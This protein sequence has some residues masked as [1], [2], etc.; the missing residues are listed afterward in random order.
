MTADLIM[1][2]WCHIAQLPLLAL[3]EMFG[4]VAATENKTQ[5]MLLVRTVRCGES[6]SGQLSQAHWV[7][8]IYWSY[9]VVL[10]KDPVM[11][12]SNAFVL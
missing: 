1:F 8:K 5:A 4:F 7:K 6:D 10:F 11:W 3:V 2:L 12:S 9:N